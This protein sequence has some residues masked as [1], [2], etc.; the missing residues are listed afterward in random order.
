M[1][2]FLLDT[3]AWIDALLAPEQLS[4]EARGLIAS[5]ETFALCS[6]SLIELTRKE[7]RGEIALQMPVGDWLTKV[8]LPPR[9]INILPITPEI[10][11]DATRLPEP[12]LNRQGKPHKDPADQIIVATARNHGA[13]L[14]T[15]DRVLLDYR[16][17]NT[18][19]SRD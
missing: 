3:C 18:L 11:V 13:T 16:F 12:F 1:P 14:I 15:S 19:S 7:A 17:V 5:P 2:T 8:A 6:I 9:K 4:A 10:A